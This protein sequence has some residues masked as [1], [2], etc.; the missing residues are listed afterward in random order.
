MTDRVYNRFPNH[1]EAIKVLM[2]ENASF[3]EM[4]VDYEEICTWI[5]EYGPTRDQPSEE[6]EIAWE[7][8]RDLEDE[9]EKALK[10]ARH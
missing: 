8:M 2:Q 1:K 10:Q 9:I 7:L 3:K 6:G 5:D 4:C